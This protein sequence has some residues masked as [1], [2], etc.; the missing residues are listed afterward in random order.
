MTL[1]DKLTRIQN[2]I[3]RLQERR[4]RVRK[5]REKLN[6]QIALYFYKD[7]EKIF[8]KDFCPSFVVGFLE[9]IQ[10]LSSQIQKHEWRKQEYS[11]CPCSQ[12][13]NTSPINKGDKAFS[14][15]KST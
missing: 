14:E 4:K 2:Q 5:Q 7:V 6:C 11:S 3:A 1:G 12:D 8:G 13:E 9:Q 10:I 15:G